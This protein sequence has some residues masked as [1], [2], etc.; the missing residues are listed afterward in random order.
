ME[1]LKVIKKE[2][3]SI[4]NRSK[5]LG[6]AKNFIM[7][8]SESSDNYGFYGYSDQDDIWKEDRVENAIKILNSMDHNKPLLYCSSTNISDEKCEKIKCK[9]LIFQKDPSFQNALV[10]SIAGGNTMIFNKKA[11]DLIVNS[12]KSKAFASHDWMTYQI[13]SGSGGIVY[14]DK[15][16]TLLYRQH[17]KN[18]FG[19]N[20]INLFSFIKRFRSLWKGKYRKWNELNLKFLKE[21]EKL[22]TEEN[23]I[24][25]KDFMISRKS[26]FLKKMIYFLKSKVHRQK[27]MGNFALII[28]LIL[29]KA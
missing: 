27:F 23:K 13:V 19:S 3:I 7:G 8:L 12:A 14:Y 16:P 15:R 6:Y 10:Q 20:I 5:N 24:C 26:Y 18:L 28:A 9:S 11:R 22:L 17:D 1:S 4:F 25:L 2:R 29:R 21:N